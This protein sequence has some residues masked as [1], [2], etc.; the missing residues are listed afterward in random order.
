MEIGGRGVLE[1]TRAGGS[2]RGRGRGYEMVST[3]EDTERREVSDPSDVAGIR[4]VVKG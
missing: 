3:R 2:G 1:Q 4:R